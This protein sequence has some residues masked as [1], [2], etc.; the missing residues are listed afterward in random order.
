MNTL[1]LFVVPLVAVTRLVADLTPQNL[2]VLI[3]AI[4]AYYIVGES[5]HRARLLRDNEFRRGALA[6]WLKRCCFPVRFDTNSRRLLA[7]MAK[8]AQRNGAQYIFAC[9]PHGPECMQMAFGF[10]GHGG[11]LPA[12]IADNLSLVSHWLGRFLPLVRDLYS[13]VGVVSCTREIVESELCAGSHLAIIPSGIKGKSQTML[14][15][16]AHND[17]KSITKEGKLR[18][19]VHTRGDRLGI[20]ALAA[21]HDAYLVPVFSPDEQRAFALHGRWLRCWPLVLIR[22]WFGLLPFVDE[23]RVR[24]GEPINCK[25]YNHQDRQSVRNLANLYY[26]RL[27]Y[28]AHPDCVLELVP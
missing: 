3:T 27:G 17:P 21:A 14:E 8:R 18:V 13:A 16:G 7:Q 26:K 5:L 19:R 25:P 15:G 10:A 22:G 24:V 11:E 23:I 20:F 2:V 28:L 4:V 12:E 1:L 6:R 9:E